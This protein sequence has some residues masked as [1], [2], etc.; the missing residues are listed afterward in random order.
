[1]KKL[2]YSVLL[3]IPLS[4]ICQQYKFNVKGTITGVSPKAKMY[5]SY[6]NDGMEI[7]DSC[8]LKGGAFR[9]SGTVDEPKAATLVLG[10]NGKF[11]VDP[12]IDDLS[13]Y[14]ENGTA[15]VEGKDSLHNAR[16]WGTPLN[17]DN[18]ERINMLKSLPGRLTPA[19][20]IKA[21][22]AF[23][24]KHPASWVS[25]HWLVSRRKGPAV[26]DGY[27]KL[28]PA[29]KE[30]K[31]GKQ[32]GDA[33]KIQLALRTG[34]P[35][36]DFELPDPDGK[37]IR[38]SDLKGKYV[39]LD[40]WSSSCKPCRALHPA[41]KELYATLKSTGKFEILAVSLDSRKEPWVKAIN[42]DQV[43]WLHVADLGGTGRNKAAELYDVGILPTHYLISP[44]GKI[45]H[46]K[47]L[48][49]IKHD[50]ALPKE[51]QSEVVSQTISLSGLSEQTMLNALEKEKL[52]P[53]GFKED[54]QEIYNILETDIGE[55]ELANEIGKLQLPEDSLAMRRLLGRA[56]ELHNQKE[57]MKQA[58][59]VKHPDSFVSLYLL[60]SLE[61]MYTADGYITAF[62]A[63]SD[64]LKQT[65]IGRQ[66]AS[67][68]EKFK[69][70]PTGK[71]A[72]NFTRKNQYGR[73]ISL[74][75][76]RGKLVLLDF[77]GSWC[78]PCRL[79][80]PHLKELYAKYKSKGLEIV[81][82]ANEK[83]TDNL[84]EARQGWL[85]AIKKDDIN[86]VH[87]LNNDGTDTQDIVKD[88]GIANYPTKLL[89]DKDGKILM[90]VTGAANNEMDKLIEKMLD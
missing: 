83:K 18:Q 51:R 88:Y 62:A 65:G 82:V 52:S 2:I 12:N 64:R 39:M 15:L 70:S 72:M 55:R 43:P 61:S 69:L 58:F 6:L 3:A 46:H 79:T 40:F 17:A 57:R 38:L 68:L 31:T 36:P 67:S 66:I 84:E 49:K 22:T 4:G 11:I 26:A 85:A 90:R 14:L 87:V 80:H 28:S 41:L 76:Y 89:L 1:M 13:V 21:M 30:S 44:D 32:L 53:A 10:H 34:Q 73:R 81:A 16:I 75:D 25:L 42:D 37:M 86:W 33:I 29:L 63:L 5:L 9:F 59:I 48:E 60:E 77:W 8:K 74:S 23:V 20:E 35:A 56:A 71:T 50:K 24:E 45:L 78:V 47:V 27:L 54:F 19:Q 7:L